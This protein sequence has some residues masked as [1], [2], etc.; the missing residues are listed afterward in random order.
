MVGPN[1]S[2][3]MPFEP[4]GRDALDR[5]VEVLDEIVSR[6]RELA[7][8][9]HPLG[10]LC[11]PIV[12]DPGW[13]VCIH[14]WTDRF[15]SAGPTTTGK[16]AHSWDLESLVLYGALGNAV[17]ELTPDEAAGGYRIAEI[18]STSGT[19]AITPTGRRFACTEVSRSLV[20]SGEVYRLASGVFHETF[21]G[22]ATEVATLVLGRTGDQPDLVLCPVDLRAHVVT[23]RLC[24]G[25]DTRAIAGMVRDRLTAVGER[26]VSV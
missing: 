19:D 10:F 11:L 1:A 21:L 2:Q 15:P 25:E 22:A 6:R 9:R 23:R 17:L 14:V 4:L 13:G 20:S 8:V 7:A 16:H 26:G 3:P 18:A 5:C 24:T 12:R